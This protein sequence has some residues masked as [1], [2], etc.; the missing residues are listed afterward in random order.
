MPQNGEINIKFG[1]YLSLCCRREIII[2]EGATF[3]ECPNHPDLMTTWKPIE[4][5]TLESK[6]LEKDAKSRGNNSY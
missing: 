2:R 3:P 6:V 4:D 1:V 5:E